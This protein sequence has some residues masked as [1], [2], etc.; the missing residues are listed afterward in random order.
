MTF[1]L[2]ALGSTIW[3][4][5]AASLILKGCSSTIT[6]VA[7][8]WTMWLKRNHPNEFYVAALRKYGDKMA[9]L[10][11][12]LHKFGRAIDVKP[13]NMNKSQHQWSLDDNG[14]ILPGLVQVKG[15]GDVTASRLLARREELGRFANW[16]D[17]ESVKGV[18]PATIEAIGN[19]ICNEDPF[20]LAVLGERLSSVREQ[21]H[22]G[23]D[24]GTG[25]YC[26]PAPTHTATEVPYDRTPTNVSVTWLGVMRSRNLKDLFEN[27]HSRTGEVL[28][29]H[30][31]KDPHKNEWVVMQCED[32]TDVMVVTVDRWRKDCDITTHLVT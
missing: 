13:L 14:D 3:T 18:G 27:H 2:V 10:L 22:V 31:V 12:D 19:F 21:L 30:K 20:N 1:P 26:L 15:I 6:Q 28:D 4:A 24:D 11:S 32:D 29:P 16:K 9:S 17:V 8:G 7:V 25:V 5:Q 23:M